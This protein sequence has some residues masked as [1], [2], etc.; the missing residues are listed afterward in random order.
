MAM[1]KRVVRLSN[2]LTYIDGGA[3][4]GPLAGKQL[5]MSRNYGFQRAVVP[6]KVAQCCDGEVR[7]TNA[8]RAPTR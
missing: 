4:S 8:S 3:A 2:T 5:R 7:A 6:S 1:S